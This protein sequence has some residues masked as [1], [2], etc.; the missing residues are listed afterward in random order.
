MR[1]NVLRLSTS[2]EC[3]KCRPL[4]HLPNKSGTYNEM[5]LILG[6]AEFYHKIS[7][8]LRIK[9]KLSYSTCCRRFTCQ[10]SFIYILGQFDWFSN[11]Y[12]QRN[13][14]NCCFGESE[15]Q[16]LFLQL[17]RLENII[18]ARFDG[19]IGQH[20]RISGSTSSSEHF[21]WLLPWNVSNLLSTTIC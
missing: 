16:L 18:P 14:A 21:L 8:N 11:Y 12:N 17:G 9:D 13:N 20:H 6:S 4:A 10:F 3:H 15:F 19:T 7:S 1:L 2:Y 5:P